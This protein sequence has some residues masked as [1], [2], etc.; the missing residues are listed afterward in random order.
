MPLPPLLDELVRVGLWPATPEQANAQNRRPLVSLERIQ[1]IAPD[2]HA[3][4]LDPPPF[5]TVGMHARAKYPPES[6]HAG[7]DYDFWGEH[8]ALDEIDIDLALVI[9]D[10]GHGSDAVIV[11][12]FR[13]QQADPPVL[14]LKWGH[15]YD[16]PNH[17]VLVA[18]TFSEFVK[19]LGLSSPAE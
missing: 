6:I 4:Y 14:R 8:G 17:W 1:S 9:G 12:D 2:E 15:R 18:E 11:L 10:W 16:D 5:R 13:G 19:M 3:L 7:S